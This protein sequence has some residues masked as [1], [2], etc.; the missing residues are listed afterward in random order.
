MGKD[1]RGLGNPPTCTT[2]VWLAWNDV[3]EV[4]GRVEGC[5]ARVL[6]CAAN[7]DSPWREGAWADG[8][9]PDMTAGSRLSCSDLR[10]DRGNWCLQNNLHR[11]FAGGAEA[12]GVAGVGRKRTRSPS[13][14]AVPCVCKQELRRGVRRWVR[15]LTVMAVRRHVLMSGEKFFRVT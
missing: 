8:R 2:S 12:A 1:E 4:N 11:I 13:D 9:S 15:V 7:G 5:R 10:V 6:P 3:C 14:G